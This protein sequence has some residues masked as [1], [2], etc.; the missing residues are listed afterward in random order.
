MTEDELFA[1]AFKEEN[2]VVE[3]HPV[4]GETI[5]TVKFIGAFYETTNR[6]AIMLALLSLAKLA[7]LVGLTDDEFRAAAETTLAV[8]DRIDRRL[9]EKL[10]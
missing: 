1:L 4:L 3:A 10:S 9:G 8:R 2:G 7:S 5:G 6:E